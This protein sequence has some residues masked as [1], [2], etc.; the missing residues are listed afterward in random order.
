MDYAFTLT[1]RPECVKRATFRPRNQ[2]RCGSFFLFVKMVLYQA[3]QG[4]QAP[5]QSARVVRA[6]SRRY[7]ALLECLVY[8]D[9]W[10]TA[11]SSRMIALAHR[12]SHR[13]SRLLCPR[14]NARNH[15]AAPR[16]EPRCSAY[17]ASAASRVSSHGRT[18][19]K[20]PPLLPRVTRIVSLK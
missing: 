15:T 16:G 10:A 9:G 8:G 17:T 7:R 18:C 14:H 5:P 20:T 13:V 19:T 4:T 6:T 3:I 11:K 1:E 12:S 2:A